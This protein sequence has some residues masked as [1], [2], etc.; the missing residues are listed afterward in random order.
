MANL[1]DLS[2]VNPHCNGGM[3]IILRRSGQIERKQTLYYTQPLKTVDKTPIT[4]R[5]ER[6][7]WFGLQRKTLSEETLN[8]LLSGIIWNV[9]EDHLEDLKLQINRSFSSRS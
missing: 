4:I 6:C 7:V 5:F 3:F 1:C 8:E 2:Q 9:V